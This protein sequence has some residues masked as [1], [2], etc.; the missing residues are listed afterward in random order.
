MLK[1]RNPTRTKQVRF[2]FV[3]EGTDAL[4]NQAA[5]AGLSDIIEIQGPKPYAEIA[6]LH[7]EAH[8]LLV[9]G[10]PATMK[11]Y[12]LFAGA[13]LFGYLKTGRPIVGVLPHDETKKVLQRVGSRTLADVDSVSEITSVLCPRT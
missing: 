6:A 13:K 2:L 7:R 3:G 8:A 9:L 5:V 12:E 11:G 1:E 4:A 10:R